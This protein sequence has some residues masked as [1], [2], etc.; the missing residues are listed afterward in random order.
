MKSVV[1]LGERKA[2]I[3][4][5]P[6]PRA[7]EDWALV[8]IHYAPMCVEVKHFLSGKN[9]AYL[10]HEAVGEVVEVA[11]PGHVKVGDRVVVMPQFPCGK[12]SYCMTGNYVYCENNYDYMQF[13]GLPYRESTYT[14]Y[15]VK[16][17][18]LLQKIPDHI[19]YEQASVYSCALG[20]AYSAFQEL[21]LSAFDTVLI[22]GLGQIGIG[23]IINAK[24]RGAR[25]I[26][27]EQHEYRANLAKELGADAVIHPGDADT[28]KK[29]KDLCNGKGPDCAVECSGTVAGGRLCIDSVRRLGKVAFVGECYAE[30]PV[31][32]SPDMLRK[33]LKLIGIWFYNL[34][35]F[36][37]I[38]KLIEY[39]PLVNRI[40]THIFPMSEIQKAFEVAATPERIKIVLKP[41][42]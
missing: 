11:Q 8:K 16:P 28:V 7:K 15:I 17:S 18:W 38:I 27:V 36:P 40:V 2:G 4:D 41:W 21:D 10:G 33:G 37:N 22:T 35:D 20:P 29:I 34:N 5:V 12:C 19:S 39:S 6:D 1:I 31:I 13:T 25:V 30:M 26:A 14:Q 32:I 42:E 9:P 24:Y 23:A 3:I